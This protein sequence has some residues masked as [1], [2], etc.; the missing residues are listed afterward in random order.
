VAEDRVAVA[1]SARPALVGATVAGAA[2]PNEVVT[3]SV[4]LRPRSG[5]LSTGGGEEAARARAARPDDAARLEAF[6]SSYGLVVAERSLA[7][8]TVWLRGRLADLGAAFGVEVVRYRFPG[9]THRG[10][11]GSIQVPRVLAGSVVAV[12]GLDDR[13]AAR[14]HLRVAVP[15]QVAAPFTAPQVGRLYD[16]PSTTGAGRT[17]AVLELGGG[18]STRDLQ[19]YFSSLG[20]S[21][22]AVSSVSI[23]GATNSPSSPPQGADYEVT[24]DL[25]VAG[26]VAS[27]AALEVYFAPNTEQGFVDALSA[28]VH[29]RPAVISV[30]WGAPES[31]W[32][33]QA[34]AA[35]D[36]V[37]QDAAVLGV[38]VCASS[39]DR[40]S[41]DGVGDGL[42]HV[43]FPASH[44]VVIGCGGTRLTAA[45][46]TI[47]SEVVWNDPSGASGGGVSDVYPLP[48]WQQG[49]GVPP[50][51]NP[52]GHIGRGV[53]D[54]AG[55][56]D[57]QTGYRVLVGG[58]EQVLGG[59]SAVAP[60]WAG[61][62]ALLSE[63]LGGLP[64]PLN[65]RL[66][67]LAG[68][69]GAFHDVTEGSNGAYRARS[70]WDACTGWGSPDGARLLAAL[71][72]AA[73]SVDPDDIPTA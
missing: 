14:P 42:A 53:P 3:V 9:G 5:E 44:P 71:R 70:G 47:A 21:L 49:A 54:V 19:A 10:Y 27:A 7:R 23:D 29:V 52:G 33:Q 72:G 67:A 73:E 48:S 35:F 26:S 31:S 50:S 64:T 68:G 46:G 58:A 1:G 59:T 8:R 32:S 20:L 17:I 16:F 11:L 51:A 45:G 57:P 63:A 61:L 2:D 22:P 15:E 18:Y 55:N 65:P 12:L 36:G 66:Y 6:A 30:S 43:D 37:L 39:G 40:G 69:S 60:L 24:L 41:G 38:A 56:A 4:V 25:E 34:L 28:A 62:L 13:P